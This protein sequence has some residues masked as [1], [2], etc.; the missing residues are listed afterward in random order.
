LS[1]FAA[2]GVQE[3]E[4]FAGRETAGIAAARQQL[5]ELAR[6]HLAEAEAATRSLPTKLKL[7]FV[8]AGLLAPQLGL[9]ATE[10]RAFVLPP[11]L[12]DWRKLAIL[13]WRGWRQR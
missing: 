4:I 8:S 12:A 11:D 7:A 1:I 6:D 5:C 3:Q 13:A 9:V 2:N 10:P